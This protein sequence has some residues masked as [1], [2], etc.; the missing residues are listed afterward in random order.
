MNKQPHLLTDSEIES[1]ESYVRDHWQLEYPTAQRVLCWGRHWQTRATTAE[2]ALADANWRADQAVASLVGA[3]AGRVDA[4]RERDALRE[5]VRR[6]EAVLDSPEL[7]E[8]LAALEHER[9][10]GWMEYQER[11]RCDIHPDTLEPFPERWARQAATS[12]QLLSWREKESDRVEVRKTLALIR[13]ALAAVECA[14][15]R[16]S[17]GCESNLATIM[18]DA[19][20][21]KG[22]PQ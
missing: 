2:A 3:E 16:T 10:S 21:A 15:S 5:R 19:E 9:W 20:N 13:A 22:E 6:L 17:G 12:Y 18:F 14:E 8:S 4:I 7:L 1:L 11:R